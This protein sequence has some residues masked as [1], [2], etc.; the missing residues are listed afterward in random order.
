MNRDTLSV[1]LRAAIGLTV[2]L[3]LGIAIGWGFWPV[4]Y[5]NTSPEALRQDYRD[6]YVVMVA[7]AYAFDHDLV[8]ARS[9]L[10]QLSPQSPAVAAVGLLER[11]VEANGSPA[12]IARVAGLAQALGATVDGALAPPAEG[13]Q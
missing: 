5:T 2:G 12:D 9:R 6:D 1:V 8:Q 13:S 3:V 7:T 11:L 10:E 4:E